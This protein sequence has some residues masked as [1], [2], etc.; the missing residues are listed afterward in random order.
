[1]LLN[2]VRSFAPTTPDH[3]LHITEFE[4]TLFRDLYPLKAKPKPKMHPKHRRHRSI[5]L[6]LH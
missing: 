3:R 5:Y 2:V 6:A 4:Y 1:M